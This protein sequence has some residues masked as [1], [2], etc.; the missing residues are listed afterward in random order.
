MNPIIV[1]TLILLGIGGAY[2][3]ML[4][5]GDAQVAA[6]NSVNPMLTNYGVLVC[7]ILIGV[8]LL[9]GIYYIVDVVKTSARQ[10]KFK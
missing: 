1:I 10:R 4:N 2:F 8:L 7:K 5:L 3:T 6:G 9:Y